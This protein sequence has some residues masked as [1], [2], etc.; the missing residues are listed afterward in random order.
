MSLQH[1]N[2]E[3]YKKVDEAIYKI[4]KKGKIGETYHIST[5]KIISISELVKKICAIT[6]V[7]FNKLVKLSK[8]RKGKD[9]AYLLSTSKIRKKLKWTDKTSLDEG[10]KKTLYWVD[11]KLIYLRKIPKEYKHKH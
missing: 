1:Y 8:E 11:Q 5:N 2:V 4:I 7:R 9:K 6:S 3:G 10:I